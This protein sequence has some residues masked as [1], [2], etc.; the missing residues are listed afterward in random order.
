[1]VARD[2]GLEGDNS[3][4]FGFLESVRAAHRDWRADAGAAVVLGAG[5]AARAVVAALV[6][7]GAP[8]I[9][10]CNRTSAKAERLAAALLAGDLGRALAD[11]VSD[12]PE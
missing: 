1:V 9:R 4:G 7:A 5:G 8:E 12:R 2:G 6:D 10:V 3:D 11:V